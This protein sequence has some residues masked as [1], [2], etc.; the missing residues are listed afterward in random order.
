MTRKI[1]GTRIAKYGMKIT[2]GPMATIY[3]CPCCKHVERF[4]NGRRGVGR[5]HGLR[6]GGGCFS[7]M[8]AHIRRD[9]P[10][11]TK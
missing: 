4:T 11:M 1:P 5:G 10:E 7:R 3:Q 2:S 8:C 6:E 9:H